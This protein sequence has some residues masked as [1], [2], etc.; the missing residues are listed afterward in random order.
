M[1]PLFRLQKRSTVTEKKDSKGPK[2]KC[3][4]VF[5]FADAK[6]S[7]A[8]GWS[9]TFQSEA[10]VTGHWIGSETPETTGPSCSFGIRNPR[11]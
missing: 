10:K 7:M 9:Q 2:V 1:E 11:R 6:T 3:N 8:I 4:G 5:D